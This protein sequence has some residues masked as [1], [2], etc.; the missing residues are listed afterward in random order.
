PGNTEDGASAFTTRQNQ[1]GWQNDFQLSEHQRFTLALERLEQRVNGDVAI[2]NAFP[3]PPTYTN[4]DRT[5]RNT[6]SVTGV[7]TGVFG[8]HHLQASLRHDN[9][10]QYGGETTGALAYGVDITNR[11]R[12]TVA[13]SAAVRAP[14][15]HEL[16]SPAGG[17][18]HLPP[19]A[20]R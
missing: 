17:A 5:E 14:H 2:W 8:R 11:I 1:Y 7:Y 10:S 19:A 9:D 16:Y 12:A 20:A 3:L 15:F 6:N 18:P 4:Y 13:G